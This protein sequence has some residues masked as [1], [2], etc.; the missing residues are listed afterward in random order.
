MQV[1]AGLVQVLSL[2]NDGKRVDKTKDNVHVKH[3]T[4]GSDI[5]HPTL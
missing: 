1:T 4:H 2:G 5:T 3:K